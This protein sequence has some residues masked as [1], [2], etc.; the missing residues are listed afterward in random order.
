MLQIALALLL[1]KVPATQDIFATL[2]LAIEALV[3]STE[4]GTSFVFGHLGGGATPYELVNPENSIVLAFRVLPLILVVSVISGLLLYLQVLPFIMRGITRLLK[5]SL[6]IGGAVGMAVSA[7]AFLGMVESPLLIRPYL[8]KMGRGELFAVMTAGMA[9]IA[10]TMLALEASVISNVLPNAV[11]HLISAS[12]ISLPAVLYVSHLLVPHLGKVSGDA[13]EVEVDGSSVIDVI[14]KST[15]SGL[16]ILLN[17]IAMLLVVV[18]LVHLI[19]LILGLA[20]NVFGEPISVQRILGYIMAPYVWLMGIPWSE[21]V[22][23]GQLM[24]IK[25]VLTEFIAYIQLG[26][27]PPGTL[28]ERSTVIMAYALCGFA[29]F[30]SLGV[31]ISGLTIMVPERRS[32]ILSLGLK[33]IVSGT[34]CTS[35]TACI[36]GL[37]Y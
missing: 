32:E 14:V 2:N 10:G 19:N 34:L 9:T 11:G 28:S 5:D 27:L 13:A 3:E 12:L 22:P 8:S 29:N 35:L 23:A 31:M 6:G 24:G 37:I 33:A 16:Q 21:A 25:T 4:A 26:Q 30:I 1:L 36:V 18:A 20:P 17:V 15:Q 7:N